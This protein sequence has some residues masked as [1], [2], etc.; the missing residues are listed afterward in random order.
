[1]TTA[2]KEI[3]KSSGSTVY[4]VLIMEQRYPK[5]PTESTL[6]RITIPTVDEAS[7]DNLLNALRV[8]GVEVLNGNTKFL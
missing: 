6:R 2:R 1:M 5:I 3:E 4:S 8:V 7:A